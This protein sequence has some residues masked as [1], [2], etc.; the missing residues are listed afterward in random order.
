MRFRT[1]YCLLIVC[2]LSGQPVSAQSKPSLGKRLMEMVT[3]PRMTLDT[4][5]VYRPRPSW[6]FSVSGDLRQTGVTQDFKYYLDPDGRD[7]IPVSMAMILKENVYT[8]LG[9]K[10]GYGGLSLGYSFEV[11][12]K[13]AGYSKSN[14]L[15]YHGAGLLLS[16]QYHN[17]R[18]PLEYSYKLDTDPDSY[19]DSGTYG[20][21]GRMKMLIVDGNYTFN[22]KTFA[23]SAAYKGN[24]FQRRS[25]GSWMLGAKYLQGEFSMEQKFSGA[26]G[27]DFSQLVLTNLRA[28][29][30]QASVG[31]GYSLN[32]V[33]LH[34]NPAGKKEKGLRNLTFNLTVLPMLTLFNRQSFAWTYVDSTG[35]TVYDDS[36]AMNAR[37][38]FNYTAK[39]AVAFAWDRYFLNVCSAYDSFYHKGTIHVPDSAR[40]ISEDITTGGLFTK[41]STTLHFM[42]RF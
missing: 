33:P 22:R 30:S 15:S 36:S 34:R 2:L 28:G 40:R 7:R 27:Y 3:N 16:F 6:H 17:I 12:R 31:A 38:G 9:F 20:D 14:A 42:V 29:T 10:G 39:A 24:F 32:L 21:P 37:M 26:A 13:S 35:K 23:Y 5:A 25:A 8:G 11:G 41:W 1:C 18:Q 4:S 19:E